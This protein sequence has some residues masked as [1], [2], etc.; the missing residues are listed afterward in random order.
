VR[1]QIKE[2]EALKAKD[3][4]QDQSNQAVKE[5]APAK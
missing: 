2:R 3:A 1:A 5:I 4:A